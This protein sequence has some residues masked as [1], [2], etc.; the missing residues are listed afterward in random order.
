MLETRLAENFIRDCPEGGIVALGFVVPGFGVDVR[1]NEILAKGSG[2]VIG[3]SGA[4][5]SGNNI[6]PVEP[7]AGGS[8]IILTAGLDNNELDECQVLENRIFGLAGDGIAIN[9]AIKSATI[10]NNI[11]QSV[12]GGGIVM[13]DK[14]RAKKLTIENN[15]LLEI[16]P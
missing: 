3:V 9:G 14:S 15:H 1:S 12:D 5:I 6:S 11:I 4:R 7:D 10:K 8:G 13:D 16:T 2:I